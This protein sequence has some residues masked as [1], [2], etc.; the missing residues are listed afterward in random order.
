MKLR[1]ALTRNGLVFIE[2]ETAVGAYRLRVYRSTIKQ[3]FRHLL[4]YTN[5]DLE[6]LDH[7]FM[8]FWH[9]GRGELTIYLF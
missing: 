9:N 5:E 6:K 2:Y 4:D 8:R 1:T 3:E 7:P